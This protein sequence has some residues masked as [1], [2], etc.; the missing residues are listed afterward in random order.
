VAGADA[1]E[2]AAELLSVLVLLQ[3][4]MKMR[5]ADAENSNFRSMS[6]R[7]CDTHAKKVLDHLR[8]TR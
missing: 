6:N 2:L 7:E 3:P 1:L 4:A 8:C 5:L